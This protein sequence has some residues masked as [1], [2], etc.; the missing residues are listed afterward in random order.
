MS[1]TSM[2]ALR[3]CIYSKRFLW[4]SADPD[5]VISQY[6]TQACFMLIFGSSMK[7][8]LLFV[9]TFSEFGMK[10]SHCHKLMACRLCWCCAEIGPGKLSFSSTGRK[11]QAISSDAL[12][13]VCEGGGS[14]QTLVHHLSGRK[15]KWKTVGECICPLT[16]NKYKKVHRIN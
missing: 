9:L 4:M 10:V 12:V 15:E 14:S 1:Q 2:L 16:M 5:G 11:A 8:V 7:S 3:A 13:W 6:K